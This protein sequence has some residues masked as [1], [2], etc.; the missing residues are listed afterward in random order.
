MFLCHC[1]FMKDYLEKSSFK[2]TLIKAKIPLKE[3]SYVIPS[4][5][6]AWVDANMEPYKKVF[7]Q[8]QTEGSRQEEIKSN[9][10]KFFEK[11]IITPPT[12]RHFGD[13]HFI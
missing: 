9:T 5:T 4:Y 13:V 3:K 6:I 2:E 12:V 1:I 10:L 7:E 8:W 11:H